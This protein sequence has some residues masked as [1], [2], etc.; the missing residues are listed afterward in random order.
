MWTQ[1]DYDKEWDRYKD[2]PIEALKIVK[3]QLYG[4]IKQTEKQRARLAAVRALL[5]LKQEERRK[6]L[7]SARYARKKVGV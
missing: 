7:S 6:A 1:A 3:N 5:E 4:R 2:A